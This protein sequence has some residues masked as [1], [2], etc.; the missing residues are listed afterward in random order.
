SVRRYA[1]ELLAP[2]PAVIL[3]SVSSGAGAL[4]QATRT[5]PIVFTQTPDP[6]GAGYV[7][8]LARPGGS[9]TGFTNMEYSLSGKYLELL[10]EIAPRL[11][12]AAILRDATISQGIGQFGAIQAVAPRLGVELRPI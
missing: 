12:R 8:S 10:K 9:A 4:L 6:V 11:A 3:A 5:V 1:A 2:A 7:D